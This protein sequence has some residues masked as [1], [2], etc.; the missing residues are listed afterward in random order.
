MRSVGHGAANDGLSEVAPSSA[1][2]PPLSRLSPHTPKVNQLTAGT[3]KTRPAIRTCDLL[4]RRRVGTSRSRTVAGWLVAHA[5]RQGPPHHLTAMPRA[6]ARRSLP[7]SPPQPAGPSAPVGPVGPVAPVTPFAPVAPVEPLGPVGPVEPD[8]TPVGPVAP[9]TPLDPL[10]PVGPVAPVTP[11]AC[12]PD[13]PV[14][15]P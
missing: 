5:V 4:L 2:N 15:R 11:V 13:G 3:S 6:Q 1:R 14:H 12:L 9:V 10:L 7:P 8:P